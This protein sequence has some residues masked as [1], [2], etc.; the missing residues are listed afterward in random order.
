MKKPLSQME[1]AEALLFSEKAK[2]GFR[3][4]AAGT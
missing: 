1:A 4:K 3:D 2:E